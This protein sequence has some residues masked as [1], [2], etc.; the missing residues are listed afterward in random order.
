MENLKS[1][2]KYKIDNVKKEI[3]KLEKD[4]EDL[5]KS[6]NHHYNLGDTAIEIQSTIFKNF[7]VCQICGDFSDD[8]RD[9]IIKD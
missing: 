3:K 8:K 7:F 6:C 5:K 4:L 1:I 2:L 9:L